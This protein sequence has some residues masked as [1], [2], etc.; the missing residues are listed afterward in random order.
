MCE[1]FLLKPA[2]NRCGNCKD[3]PDRVRLARAAT[4]PLTSA[5]AHSRQQPPALTGD[6]D[7]KL[8]TSS[9]RNN[10]NDNS[11]HLYLTL[12]R[13]RLHETLSTCN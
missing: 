13:R 9:S 3:A 5:A 6:D 2:V 12:E 10:N 8:Q 7:P 11:S 4:S 1:P